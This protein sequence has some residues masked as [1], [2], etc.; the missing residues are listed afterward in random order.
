[1]RTNLE[2]SFQIAKQNLI[3]LDGEPLRL[4]IGSRKKPTGSKPINY[5]LQHLPTGKYVFISSLFPSQKQPV[6]GSQMFSLDYEGQN[7]TCSIDRDRGIAE[8]NNMSK[9]SL[10]SIINSELG[11][12]ITP[13]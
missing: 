2:G 10:S 13:Q 7:Y 6:N 3:K 1:M 11:A 9:N 8:I 12:K 4:V 5:L